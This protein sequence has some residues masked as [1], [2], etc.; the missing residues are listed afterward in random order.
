MSYSKS[1][2]RKNLQSQK[3]KHVWDKAYLSVGCLE[4]SLQLYEM[5]C[6]KYYYASLYYYKMLFYFNQYK[7]NEKQENNNI[8]KCAS[9]TYHTHI[10]AAEIPRKNPNS[11]CFCLWPSVASLHTFMFHHR[12]FLMPAFVVVSE[13]LEAC[14]YA[15]IMKKLFAYIQT[16]KAVSCSFQKVKHFNPA[17][18]IRTSP[19]DIHFASVVFVASVEHPLGLSFGL[20]WNSD[21]FFVLCL[22][23][24]TLN[25]LLEDEDTESRRV[26]AIWW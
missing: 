19:A 11:F 14:C 1:V 17:A 22:M 20:I 21:A 6:L 26:H 9:S 10:R 8:K 16:Y 24:I 3:E 23:E 13:W 7:Q 15:F 25:R 12:K 18:F 5:G 4:S 2:L